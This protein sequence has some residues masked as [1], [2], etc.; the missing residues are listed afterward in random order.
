[1]TEGE[2]TVWANEPDKP[3]HSKEKIRIESGYEKA[4]AHVI[5]SGMVQGV[6]FRSTLRSRA[7]L[8]E[9]SGWTKNT[10]DGNVEAVFEGEKDRVEN[11]ITFCW[12]GPPG[13]FVRDVQV[14]WKRPRIDLQ[15]F[16][17]RY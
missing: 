12:K 17:I 2:K 6:F 9:I 7:K 5:I 1:M 8:L 16:E 14:E 3:G 13:A 10:A 11:I 15:G 4:R